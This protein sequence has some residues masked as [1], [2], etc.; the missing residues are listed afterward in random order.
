MTISLVQ[1]MS[2]LNITKNKQLAESYGLSINTI[3]YEDTSRTKGSCWDC[4]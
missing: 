4:P 2:N 3:V 1:S